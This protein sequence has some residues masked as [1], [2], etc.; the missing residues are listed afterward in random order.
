MRGFVTSKKLEIESV[1][2]TVCEKKLYGPM[3]RKKAC[4]LAGAD[5]CTHIFFTVDLYMC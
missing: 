4:L 5:K 1:M 3:K 2:D